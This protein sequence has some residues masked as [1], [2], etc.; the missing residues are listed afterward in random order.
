MYVELRGKRYHHQH[1]LTNYLFFSID[2]SNKIKAATTAPPPD[3]ESN[4]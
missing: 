4:P 2:T 3:S 1:V